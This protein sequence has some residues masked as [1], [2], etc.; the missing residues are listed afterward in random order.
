MAVR[1]NR[2]AITQT[3]LVAVIGLTTVGAPAL[4]FPAAATDA[5]PHE[6]TRVGAQAR[7]LAD[8]FGR[9][10]V[11]RAAGT[12]SDLRAT[13]VN[14]PGTVTDADTVGDSDPRV[15]ISDVA[16]VTAGGRVRFAATLPTTPDPRT[17]PGWQQGISF[18]AWAIDTTGDNLE[19][20]EVGVF[21]S[22]ARSIGLVV[23]PDGRTYFC[24]SNTGYSAAR[25][26]FSASVPLRCLGNPTVLNFQ[27]GAR[28]D[29]SPAGSTPVQV[30]DTAPDSSALTL[31]VTSSAPVAAAGYFVDGFGHLA[32]FGLANP[33]APKPRGGPVF[34]FD[35]ARGIGATPDG[36]HLYVNDGFGGI[37]GVGLGTNASSAQIVG[38]PY[39]PGWDIA[40]GVAIAAN[41]R[42]GY[43]V[44]G[45]GGVHPFA[46]GTGRTVPAAVGGPY[47][48]TWDIVR[49]IAV[50]PN[51]RGGYVLDGFGG[52]HWFGIG[53]SR[54]APTLVGAPYWPGQD[55]ARGV[56]ILPDGTGGYIVDSLGTLSPFGI[57]G[58]PPAVPNVAP[59]AT[60]GV[61]V[62]PTAL[63]LPAAVVRPLVPLTG[64]VGDVVIDGSNQF[65][66]ATNT[67]N[68]RIEVISL[69]THAVAAT[70][71]VGPTP[72]GIDFSP[73]G[74]QLYV[75]NSGDSTVSVVDVAIRAQLRTITIPAGASRDHPYWV[76]AGSDGGL[77]VTTAF[78]GGG[79]NA[80]MVWVDP[81]T[82]TV[83]PIASTTD[84]THVAASRDRTKMLVVTNQ[85]ASGDTFSF[86]VATHT[87]SPVKNLNS[88]VEYAAM[89]SNGSVGLVGGVFVLD[90]G[91]TVLGTVNAGSGGVALNAAGTVGY[92]VSGSVVQVVNTTTFATS[93]VIYLTDTAGDG[94]GNDTNIALSPD[95]NTLAVAT[96]HGVAIV[97]A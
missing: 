94:H 26:T 60:R 62:V 42:S 21:M 61:A 46:I 71:N 50:L 10:H 92:S 6:V 73:D 12:S 88:S 65:A 83:T 30:G 96:A 66:Y 81:V 1:L 79:S 53:R 76:A 8:L 36:G 28:Y 48:P 49:G 80:K 3:A 38:A 7:A 41:G 25:H 23:S 52:L 91:L 67:S 77:F 47:W 63:G 2:H 58:P 11:L 84:R 89:N 5:A 64:R 9:R 43:E 56:V 95:Q 22:G 27:A 16:A 55:R 39:W 82:D 31:P 29:T 18:A 45:L 78:G 87:L 40:R 68:D 51:G 57:G 59:F 19:D 74:T 17:D 90:A 72:I 4:A 86:D 85:T 69:A 97:G 32:S 93:R 14:G 33:V 54:P 44:D 35:I 75:A 24:N 34:G 15:D 13:V 20:Y 70:I 37:H